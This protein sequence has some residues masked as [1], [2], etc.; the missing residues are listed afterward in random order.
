[1]DFEKNALG[2][3]VPEKAKFAGRYHG[4]LI[5][6]GKVIDEWDDHNIVVNEGLNAMLNIMFNGASQITSWYLG[7]F[8][9]NYVPVSSDGAAT[10]SGNATEATGY[11]AGARQTFAGVASTAQSMTNSASRASFTF[12]AT[13]TVYGAFL[14]SSP[15]INGG[16][17]TMYSGA[18][19]ATPKPVVNLDQMLLTYTFTAVSA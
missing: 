10:I 14:A 12:N 7:L 4:V 19:F 5:R 17:G 6:A 16:V 1:M 3:W 9:G 13:Q 18:Q 2:L 11:T 15:V 8:T